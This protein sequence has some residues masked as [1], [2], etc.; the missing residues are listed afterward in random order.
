MENENNKVSENI[1]QMAIDSII[2]VV[3]NSMSKEE[4]PQAVIIAISLLDALGVKEE[5]IKAAGI[6]LMIRGNEK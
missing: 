4:Q 6:R 3:S 2:M 1:R 5:E